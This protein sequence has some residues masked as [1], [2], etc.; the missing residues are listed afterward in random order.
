MKCA[1]KKPT[2]IQAKLTLRRE[3]ISTKDE[4][5]KAAEAFAVGKGIM[6]EVVTVRIDLTDQASAANINW[7][8]KKSTEKKI[9]QVKVIL[10]EV[11]EKLSAHNEPDVYNWEQYYDYGDFGKHSQAKTE[12]SAIR[13]TLKNSQEPR[14][15]I[16][17]F[18]ESFITSQP[19]SS[20]S[21]VKSSCCGA[22]P[23]Q[24]LEEVADWATK[25]TQ[26]L[27]NAVEEWK[28]QKNL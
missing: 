17:M 3:C 21:K 9:E 12:Y 11:W 10:D 25:D 23:V 5:T 6:E 22:R 24:D 14:E 26:S 8:S 15:K 13:D 27:M 16:L 4:N 2:K 28:E 20:S 18:I 7:R 1:S 19:K